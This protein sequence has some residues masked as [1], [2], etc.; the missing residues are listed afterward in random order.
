MF[1]LKDW[2]CEPSLE[3]RISGLGQPE[4]QI[5]VPPLNQLASDDSDQPTNMPLVFLV[6]SR[7]SRGPL[8]P[9]VDTDNIKRIHN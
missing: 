9:P 3:P 5:S 6:V 8:P 7:I 4:V 1:I 2:I